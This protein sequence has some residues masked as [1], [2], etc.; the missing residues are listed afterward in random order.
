MY[1]LIQVFARS[2]CALLKIGSAGTPTGCLFATSVFALRIA[3]GFLIERL[4]VVEVDPLHARPP[5]S[6]ALASGRT[7]ASVPP[8]STP[9]FLFFA[10]GIG[11]MP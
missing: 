9:A 1:G 3:C 4:L 7:A 11:A 5:C 6:A 2:Y 8:P 10:S